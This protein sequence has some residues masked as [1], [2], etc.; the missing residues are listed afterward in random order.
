MTTDK[1]I[2]LSAEVYW[3]KRIV[4]HV[5]EILGNNQAGDEFVLEI[6]EQYQAG[7]T[8]TAK[9]YVNL[10]AKQSNETIPHKLDYEVIG[11][12]IEGF[13]ALLD[14]KRNLLSKQTNR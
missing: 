9:W 7:A 12:L 3:T 4:N 1:T 13:I 2:N 14:E 5:K 6:L 11:T 10:L 8:A